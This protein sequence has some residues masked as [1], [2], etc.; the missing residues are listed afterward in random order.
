MSDKK[1]ISAFDQ[2]ESDVSLEQDGVWVQVGTMGFKVARAGGDNDE[3]VKAVSK[4]F[5]PYQA[6][7]SADTFPKE[8]AHDLVVGVF[9]DTVIKDWKD[10]YGRDKQPIAFSKEAAKQLF[11]ELPNLFMAVQAEA[12]KL[13][14]FRRENLEAAAGN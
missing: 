2:F 13:S 14:N 7:L 10:V 4:R 6:A 12:Q 5:K 9:V 11:I 8:M 3:F 1:I